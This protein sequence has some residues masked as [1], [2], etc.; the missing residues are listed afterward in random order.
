MEITFRSEQAAAA[1]EKIKAERP[2]M[3]VG[4]G[5]VI[6]A[7]NCQ[8]AIDCGS[9]F[10]VT[11]GITKKLLTALSNMSIPAIPGVTSVSEAMETLE[12]GFTHQKLFP[13]SIAGG[14]VLKST[15][16]FPQINFMPS[17]G[18]SQKMHQIIY[19][20]IMFFVSAAL[21]W[22]IK[23][24]LRKKAGVSCQLHQT[25]HLTLSY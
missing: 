19:L 22:W 21:G 15:R 10:V 14:Q 7:H 3:I 11:P 18:I 12:N 23:K 25:T 2:E 6:N 13:S 9:D 20:S 17:G 4:A 5:T 1:I 8:T 24:W 16:T